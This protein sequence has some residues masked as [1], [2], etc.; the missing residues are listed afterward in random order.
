M[1]KPDN[2]TTAKGSEFRLERYKYI[3]Q[4]LHSL[5]E[6]NHKYLSL[7]Q[8]LAT[9]V[10]GGG[11]AIFV[12][13]KELKIDAATA[14]VGIRGLLGLLIILTLFVSISIVA[15]VVSWFDYRHEEVKLLRKEVGAEFRQPPTLKNLWRWSETYLVAFL[16]LIVVAVYVFVEWQLIPLIH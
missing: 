13:W 14:R 1:S 15:G 4:Q 3:L 11:I 9:A 10:I 5:N 12:G 8:A 16:I 7:F 6:N 2:A